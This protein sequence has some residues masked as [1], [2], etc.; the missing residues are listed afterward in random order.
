MEW[1]TTKRVGKVFFDYNQNAMGKTIASIFSIRP[2]NSATVSMPVRWEDLSTIFPTD[3]TI[4]NAFDLVKKSFDP[5]K[6][7]LQK[8]QDINKLLQEISKIHR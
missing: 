2:T 6:E 5:W 3:F 1:D 4:L 8:K 7:I